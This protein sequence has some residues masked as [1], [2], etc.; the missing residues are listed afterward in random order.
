MPKKT[1][2][3]KVTEVSA[4][5][6]PG[7]ASR[8][9]GAF[10]ASRASQLERVRAEV[11]RYSSR[12]LGNALVNTA[13]RNGPVEDIHASG[14]QGSPLDVRRITPAEERSSVARG[15]AAALPYNPS[16]TRR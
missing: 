6:E 15:A 3:L 13:W 12:V 9:V 14:F 16:M 8:L 5:A 1:S 11:E 4:L 2:R 7:L 10:R